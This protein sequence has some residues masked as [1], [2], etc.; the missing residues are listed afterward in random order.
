MVIETLPFG[1]TGHLS[2]R[3]IFGAAALGGMS[4][5]RAAVLVSLDPLPPTPMLAM[6]IRSLGDLLS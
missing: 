5:D 2:T 3:I 1:A 6:A 4:P